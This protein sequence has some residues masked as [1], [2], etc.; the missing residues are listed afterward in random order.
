MDQQIT[1]CHTPSYPTPT[2]ITT[3][4]I[5][6]TSTPTTPSSTTPTPT[7]PNPSNRTR[8]GYII[9]EGAG[10]GGVDSGVVAVECVEGRAVLDGGGWSP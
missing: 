9:S 1:L 10:G 4:T 7:A 2:P 5:T 3:P 6:P 8:M